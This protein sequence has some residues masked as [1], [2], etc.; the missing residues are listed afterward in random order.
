MEH[1]RAQLMHAGE[2]ELH[3]GLHTSRTRHH[4]ARSMTGQVIQQRRLAH[5]D[6]AAHHQYPAFTRPDSFDQ[7]V[8]QLTFVSPA[9]QLRDACTTRENHGHLTGGEVG[10]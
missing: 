6:F 8:K 9:P 4:T 2:G 10:A 3:L 5:T 1:R 7:P